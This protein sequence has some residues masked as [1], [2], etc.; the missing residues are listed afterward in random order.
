[1]ADTKKSD[2]KKTDSKKT[3]GKKTTSKKADTNATESKPAE[4]KVA[5]TK[6]AEAKAAA[7]K[8]AATKA[9]AT[10][11]AAT[12]PA[13]AKPAEATEEDKPAVPKAMAKSA[14]YKELAAQTGLEAKEVA[15]VF[16]ALEEL[17]KV[18]LS[19]QGPGLFVIPN[20]VKLK[21]IKKEATPARIGV[22]NPFKKGELM[23]V[24]EKPASV[25]VKPVILKSLKDVSL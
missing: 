23:D 13:E 22:P 18:Q 1:M 14:V 9:D 19:P 4:T 7:T 5:E 17:I 11:P 15:A 8:P 3:D 10:K 2:S 25:K 24:K 12:K 21:L 6:P 20:L 16:A